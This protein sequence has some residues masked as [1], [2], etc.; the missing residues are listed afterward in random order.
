[1]DYIHGFLLSVLGQMIIYLLAN[2]QK[3]MYNTCE[4]DEKE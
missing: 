1:M 4:I 3:T 2:P